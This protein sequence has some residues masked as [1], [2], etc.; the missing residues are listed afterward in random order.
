MHLKH[1][2]IFG[3][4]SFPE[5]VSLSFS[6]GITAVAG[7]NGSGKSNIV[8]ALLWVLGEQSPKTLRIGRIQDVIFAG[9]TSRKPISYAEVSISIDNCD[10]SL[11]IPYSEVVIKRSVDRAGLCEYYLNGTPCRLKDIQDLLMDTGIG[12]NAYAIV[13][14]GKIEEILNQRPE[15]RRYVLEEAVGIGRYRWR[16]K[17]ATQKLAEASRDLERL[18]DIIAELSLRINEISPEADRAL[19]YL[20]LW[21]ALRSLEKKR[22][23]AE[24]AR[25]ADLLGEIRREIEEI[26]VR[27]E[28]NESK[29][30]E[31]KEDIERLASELSILEEKRRNAEREKSQ[32]E[33]EKASLEGSI[34]ALRSQLEPWGE[35]IEEEKSLIDKLE[36]RR[37]SLLEDLAHQEGDLLKVTSDW[38]K[39]KS[40]QSEL[41]ETL[42]NK[43]SQLKEKKSE[44]EEAKVRMIDLL[45]EKAEA[46]K[47]L[48]TNRTLRESFER[49]K[50]R[51][52]EQ[53]EACR[54]EAERCR[55]DLTEIEGALKKLE[56]EKAHLQERL[57]GLRFAMDSLNAELATLNALKSQ[58]NASL[59]ASKAKLETLEDMASRRDGFGSGTRAI[60]HGIKR[61]E[62]KASGIVG[63]LGDLIEVKGEYVLALAAA[64]GGAADYLVVEDEETARRCIEYLKKKRAGRSTF[65]PLDM[66]RPSSLSPRERACVDKERGA[67]VLIS[68]LTYDKHVEPAILH[69]LG[70]VVV[71]LDLDQAVRLWRAAGS[72]LRVVTLAG[73]VVRQG[74]SITG[75]HFAEDG[76][77]GVKPSPVVRKSTM[78]ALRKRIR[79][80]NAHLNAIDQEIRLKESRIHD[81]SIASEEVTRALEE[82][83]RQELA[84]QAEASNIA[85]RS[86]RLTE[87]SENLKKEREFVSFRV[88]GW[89]GGTFDDL[90]LTDLIE[91][92]QAEIAAVEEK[93]A[94]WERDIEDLEGYVLSLQEKL[95]TISSE[96][97][98]LKEAYAS[99]S[100]RIS[101]TKGLLLETDR[102][103]AEA[104]ERFDRLL[105]RE[106]DYKLDLEDKESRLREI[107]GVL[108]KVDA[109]YSAL[110]EQEDK[111]RL[112]LLALEKYH[113]RLVGK[114]EADRSL[115]ME[116]RSLEWKAQ[117]EL[118]SWKT[119][120]LGLTDESEAAPD[121][122]VPDTAD[123]DGLSELKDLAVRY[124]LDIR[125]EASVGQNGDGEC[126]TNG[127]E[128]TEELLALIQ[129]LK[130]RL[131]ALGPVK[132]PLIDER[133]H[134]LARR[135][136]L[137]DQRRDL[138]RS[139]AS[140]ASLLSE[141]DEEIAHRFK[142]SFDALRE[143][144]KSRFES[145]FG[146]GEADLLLIPEDDWVSGGIEVIARP[147][148]RRVK[149][150]SGL[151]GG[152]RT[153]TGIALIFSLLDYRPSPFVVLD[154]VEA[155]LDE[156]NAARFIRML[157]GLSDRMQFIVVTHQRLTME[158]ADVI[159]GIT[160]E[161]PGAS[162][163]VSLKF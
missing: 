101:R 145:L 80:D 128:T 125:A 69:V 98:M 50:K 76:K 44:L 33:T 127:Q 11:R 121:G 23:Q 15:E 157:K 117:S 160:M 144:F 42:A 96:A 95:E 83:K 142:E 19:E 123:D 22:A 14:Q 137:D 113:R 108:K 70:R 29:S 147:P 146:G 115:L 57:E 131:D 110:K 162:V 129:I 122:N 6:P 86:R 88:G 7:P 52:E 77:D 48:S 149:Y 36:S 41:R 130:E 97:G 45:N 163:A 8:D 139:K 148:G 151:S 71:A 49:D 75:G 31:A 12:R 16:K 118:A 64:L 72:S 126:N 20:T 60:L 74:G 114:V 107:C 39:T 93:R 155:P 63:P 94:L 153:L 91:K 68:Y 89:D 66:I 38:E 26:E 102:E 1:L 111:T 150:L 25:Y 9:N 28:E 62:L 109:T 103:I 138:E 87:E 135:A 133:K 43:T 112:R 37:R 84:L 104:Q 105:G 56:E 79:E 90:H 61:A 58:K 59:V 143:R 120:L 140:L 65:L 5:R 159:Y 78:E 32:I 106:K 30:E 100:E 47:K 17:E 34:E 2:E 136:F 158:A 10:G 152:E 4:K 73:D 54:K 85:E 35:K 27:L 40:L 161:E 46:E 81:L 67:Q 156:A 13:G 119:A 51:I 116:K 21:R 18:G 92:I 24:V 82:V 124:G 134:L 99:R 3:F 53:E 132:L 55:E 141:I 154:E